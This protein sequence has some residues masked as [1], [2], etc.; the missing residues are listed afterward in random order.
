MFDLCTQFFDLLVL[1]L[2]Q[3]LLLKL[4][5]LIFVLQVVKQFA[6]LGQLV[7]VLKL[8]HLQLSI[9]KSNVMLDK[10]SL[11]ITLLLTSID[12][13]VTPCG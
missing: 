9:L 6:H 10:L 1:H 2:R 13:G 3:L 11:P 4:Y 7:L 5:L 8:Y 12:L